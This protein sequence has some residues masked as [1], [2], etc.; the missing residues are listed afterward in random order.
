MAGFRERDSLCFDPND[1]N[2][3]RADWVRP[4]I[5]PILFACKHR[6]TGLHRRGARTHNACIN[7]TAAAAAAVVMFH[8]LPPKTTVTLRE[9]FKSCKGSAEIRFYGA[10]LLFSFPGPHQRK[11]GNHRF[12]EDQRKKA[13][14]CILMLFVSSLWCEINRVKGVSCNYNWSHSQEMK[15]VQRKTVY[16]GRR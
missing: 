4:L 1:Y 2:Y 12:S 3:T 13:A 10:C 15:S 14:S 7:L 16:I 5:T 11:Q 9:A 6:S 8:D